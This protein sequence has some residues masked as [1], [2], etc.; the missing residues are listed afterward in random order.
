MMILIILSLVF[1]CDTDPSCLWSFYFSVHLLSLKMK[2]DESVCIKFISILQS[3]HIDLLVVRLETLIPLY[4]AFDRQAK[5]SMIE[6]S[7][8]ATASK[9]TT[10][11]RKS[12]DIRLGNDRFHSAYIVHLKWLIH[13]LKWKKKSR[14]AKWWKLLSNTREVR[15]QLFSANSNFQGTTISYSIYIL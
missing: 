3:I 2:C 11:N 15:V 8:L 1:D 14:L 9:W 10:Q 7:E 4:N 13:D 5:F 12:G 6:L